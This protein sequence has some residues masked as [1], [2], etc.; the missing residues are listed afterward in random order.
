MSRNKP[1]QVQVRDLSLRYPGGVE[2]LRNVSFDIRAGETLGIVGESGCGKSTLA[3]VLV[4]D[5]PGAEAVTGSVILRGR[6]G[7]EEGSVEMLSASQSALREIWGRRVATVYQDPQ[8]SLNPSYT[9]GDQIDEAVRRRPELAPE[10][11]RRRTLDLLR[12]VRIPAPESTA[13]R[14]PHQISG[15][16]QQRAVI[17]MALAANPDLLILDEPTTGLDV[18][19][20]ARILDLVE[21]LQREVNAGIVFITH[22]LAVIAQIAHRVGVMYA[23]ELVEIGDVERIFHTPAAPYTAGLLSCIP[24]IDQGGSAGRRLRTIP[25][26]V[27]SPGERPQGC[28]FSPR[29]PFVEPRCREQAPELRPVQGDQHLA[30]CFYAQEVLRTGWPQDR[31]ARHENGAPDG[32]AAP[33]LE[34]HQLTKRF[35]RVGHKY[36]FFGPVT[37]RPIMAVDGISLELRKGETLGIVGE[38][39][40]GKTTLLNCIAGL[41]RPTEGVLKMGDDELAPAV[42]HRPRSQLQRM[43][44][45]FQNPD[46]SLNPQHSVG[47]IMRRAVKV[48]DQESTRAERRARVVDLLSHVGLGEHY[49]RRRPSELSGGE[50]QRVAVA[51]ALAGHP[52]VVLADEVTSA[53]DVSVRAE[54][55]N[56]LND[57]QADEG[58]AYLFISHDMSAIRH[59]SHRVMVLYLG[60][61][62]ETG[63]VEQVFQPPYHP[64][65]EALMSAIPAPDP[66]VKTKRIRLGGELPDRRPSGCPFH[67]R[68]PRSLGAVCEEQAPPWRETEDGHRIYCHIPLEE[69]ARIPPLIEERAR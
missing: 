52:D 25:G 35:G 9:I 49:L 33:V 12:H 62:M 57:L 26:R 44:M 45:V 17:A 32:D 64:Y 20:E 7:A 55:L 46:L 37:R 61:V 66:A 15:G 27:P 60:M 38:S 58:V 51:R 4:G 50:K 28:A 63:L 14:Y 8:A 24:R 56:L 43:Q 40:C 11:T 13:Q 69:L 30:R 29:C 68:C 31:L 59:V 18:T 53:L 21:E 22:N 23:G 54:I 34:G 1:I 65:T 5:V 36:V 6:D 19:T 39:G 41:V 10:G 48:L 3:N 16:Q 47:A 42:R 2:A 67:T